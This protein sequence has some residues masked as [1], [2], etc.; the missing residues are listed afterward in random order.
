MARARRAVS[1]AQMSRQLHPEP[2]QQQ[3]RGLERQ[4]VPAV[5][6]HAEPGHEQQVEDAPDRE[7][8]RERRAPARGVE[9]ARDGEREDDA[10]RARRQPQRSTTA[11]SRSR[12]APALDQI[13]SALSACA[14]LASS[15]CGSSRPAEHPER[16]QP[17][18]AERRR[19]RRR[20][21]HRPPRRPPAVARHQRGGQAGRG[22]RGLAAQHRGQRQRAAGGERPARREGERRRGDRGDRHRRPRCRHD[23][24]GSARGSRAAPPPRRPAPTLRG[25]RAR[26]ARA[27]RPPPRAR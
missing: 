22:E 24:I 4:H 20:A 16:R 2:C 11:S 26:R 9:A 13:P 1:P 21:R 19:H 12:W 25:G 23:R 27:P 15:V 6:R 17:G 8:Q 10:E 3:D 7:R 14:R 18:A 5:A